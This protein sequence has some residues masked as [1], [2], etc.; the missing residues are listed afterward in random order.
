MAAKRPAYP[1]LLR[2]S[3]FCSP[4]WRWARAHDLV[5]RGR[6]FTR[7]RDDAW[8]GR[9]VHYLRALQRCRRESHREKL[10]LAYPDVHAARSFHEQGGP[11]ALEVQARLLAGQTTDEAARAASAPAEVI[12]AYEALFFQVADRLDARDWVASQAVGWWRFGPA[13]G[14][15]AATVLK[16]FAYHGALPVLEALSPFLL[17][18]PSLA[19]RESALAAAEG[20]LERRI[21]HAIVSEMLPW[22]TEGLRKL[23]KTRRS[24]QEQPRTAS[25]TPKSGVEKAGSVSQTPDDLLA[26]VLG[27]LRRPTPETPGEE[28][29]TATRLTG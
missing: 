1:E 4:D 12:A 15:D 9:A 20:G 8:T 29:Y 3:P 16:G 25:P 19:Q 17:N 14:R 10:A 7:R 22:G 21:L 18:G 28:A 6:Y 24:L 13:R 27:R 2:Y 5:R 26:D 23:P 11:T